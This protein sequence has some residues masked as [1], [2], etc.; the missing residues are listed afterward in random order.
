[1]IKNYWKQFGLLGTVLF[2]LAIG[3][4]FWGLYIFITFFKGE[5]LLSGAE[6]DSLSKKGEYIS[7]LVGTIWALAGVFLFFLALNL[8]SKELSLQIQ[9][10]KETKEVFLAQQE[11][12]HLEQFENSFFNLLKNLRSACPDQ[13]VLNEIRHRIIYKYSYFQDE[14]YKNDII[15]IKEGNDDGVTAANICS[16]LGFLIKHEMFEKEQ[17]IYLLKT[18]EE[19]LH[20]ANDAPL[21]KSKL[22]YR[23]ILED[24]SV[25]LGHYYRSLYHILKYIKKE[26]DREIFSLREKNDDKIKEIHKKYSGYSDL[27]QAQM[28]MYELYILFFNGLGYDEMK[29]LLHHFNFLE[30]LAIEDLIDPQ[31][32]RFYKE[33]IDEKGVVY[34]AI[35]FKSRTSEYKILAE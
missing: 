12:F 20:T 19:N 14:I 9:E 1:M 26:E 6:L 10:L 2:I 32:V 24:Y 4:I 30:N 5:Q 13:E 27:V 33:W 25:T 16:K 23:I 18:V 28:S 34:P 21:L 11:V 3:S 35:K 7:G 8:Q 22:A 17:A 31:F 15:T 29:K